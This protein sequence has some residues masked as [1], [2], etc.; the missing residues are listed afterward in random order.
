M[1]GGGLFYSRNSHLELQGK[2]LGVRSFSP[3]PNQ[4]ITVIDFRITNPSTAQFVV[5]DVDVKLDT[6]DGKTVDAAN[7]SDADA[8]RVFD[9]Y[10][11]LGKKYNPTLVT[12]EQV[13]PG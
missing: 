9:Y 5:E 1:I 11:V 13:N 4:T 2:V 3:E 7:F 10:K 12:R 8:Q 6:K